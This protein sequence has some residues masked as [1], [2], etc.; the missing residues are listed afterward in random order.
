VDGFIAA[1]VVAVRVDLNHQGKS[2]YTL[3]G[4][5]IC[6]QAIHGDKNLKEGEREVS[7]QLPYSGL[8][9]RDVSRHEGRVAR[10]PVRTTDKYPALSHRKWPGVQNKLHGT[11]LVSNSLSHMTLK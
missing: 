5:E 9:R 10:G 8:P 2:F 1:V 3:L 4:G 7:W 6:T 11:K